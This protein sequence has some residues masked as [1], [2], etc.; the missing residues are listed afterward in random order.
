VESL[1][2]RGVCEPNSLRFTL[3]GKIKFWSCGVSG[4]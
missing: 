1:L 3:L 4:L 2:V